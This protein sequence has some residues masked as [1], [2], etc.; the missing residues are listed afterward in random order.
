MS[1]RKK[2]RITRKRELEALG[3][4]L[5][6]EERDSV[7]CHTGTET[8]LH[9]HLKAEIAR[10]ANNAKSSVWTETSNE[11]GI[12][13]VILLRENKHPKALVIEIE[14]G[15]TEDRKKEKR[16]TFM[17]PMIQ[18]VLV[19]NPADFPANIFAMQEEVSKRL[20]GFL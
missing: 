15:L 17:G 3:W 18:E 12:V 7:A 20:T 5:K 10:Q 2:N 16:E 8:A 19:W 9:Y 13:D 11:E 14:T 4:N 1:K 6:S